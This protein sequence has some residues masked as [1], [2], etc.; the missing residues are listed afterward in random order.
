MA[1]TSILKLVTLGLGLVAIA[2]VIFTDNRGVRVV[3]SSSVGSSVPLSYTGAPT[4]PF[5]AEHTCV[6]CHSASPVG[7]E[8]LSIE[9]RDSTGTNIVSGY[10]AGQNYK[11]NVT[12]TAVG[13][14]W[15]F[16]ITAIDP[17]F[18]KAG[19]MSAA[20]STTLSDRTNNGREYTNHS[21]PN[22]GNW[23]FNWTA[24]NPTVG[25]V[26]F[27]AAGVKGNGNST[28]LDDPT[29]STSKA[30]PVAAATPDVSVAVAPSSVAE[31]G[32][33]NLVYTFTRTGATTSALTVNFSVGGTATFSTDYTQTGAA[34]FGASSGTVTIGAGNSTATV[35]IDP[36]A[37]STVESNETAILTVTSGSGY[38]VG[39]P[40]AATGTITNDD[41]SVSVAVSPASVTEDGATNLVYTF[42]R[43][44]VTTSALT[45]NFSVGGT[46]TFS[47][48]YTQTGAATF[49]ASSGTVTIGAG[50]STATVTIDPV[51]DSTVEPDETA[52]LTVT[53]GTGYNVGSPSAATG[54]ITTDDTSVSVAVSPSSVTEDGATN[55]V[56]T[57][58][59]TG[60]TTGALTVNFSVGGTATFNSDYTQTGA[61]TFGAS[62]GTVTIGA[63]NTA[64][65]VTIDPT[66]DATFEADETVILTVTT[67]TG[68]NVGSPSVASGTITN[69]DG[70][71]PTGTLQF[72]GASYSQGESGGTV[73]ITVTRTGGSSG[74]AS[75]QF[76]N[77][78]GGSATGGVS[79]TAGVDYITPAGTLNWG[80]GV[81]TS[82][83]FN[84]TI[85][86]DNVFEGDETVN[87]QLANATGASLGSQSTAILTITD[88]ETLQLL[89]EQ[90]GPAFN[91]AAALESLLLIRD[92]F[93]VQS[94]E[95]WWNFGPDRN[96]RV[97]LLVN[98][99]QLNPGELPSAVQVSLVDANN[100]TFDVNAEDVRPVSVLG[101]AN[102]TFRLPN[103]LAAG[104]CTVTV[105]AHSQVSN[106]GTIR[107]LAP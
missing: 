35:T 95:D 30:L 78:A 64:A 3:L 85:C 46:A 14:G 36:V 48:D 24:P 77:P 7:G 98:N 31:D 61:A 44:G 72:S 39:S 103:N 55:L 60:V 86:S 69:D 9:V 99:L 89:L 97:I 75:V 45:V 11:I 90:S 47:T 93:H 59:R 38:N 66:A 19:D 67:G 32:A 82:Q 70:A 76:S 104:V 62:S 65:T 50:N 25:T 100:Q 107:I 20:D 101:F 56:Y 33:T 71:P 83:I 41:T 73:T 105:K 43:T 4:G 80:D 26:T 68:Y 96:T 2:V 88:D 17:T 12:H 27:Y 87:L 21:A 42:T 63:G 79:C 29:Y 23:T 51:A 15:G 91:Q 106:T 22:A 84:I 54:T 74:A 52:I 1:Q 5:G 18:A 58:T 8:S 13:P 28:S 81:I 34:T 53:S 16:Q 102:V 10:Q 37:D 94:V 57:F 49:G 92:P 6:D 40:S